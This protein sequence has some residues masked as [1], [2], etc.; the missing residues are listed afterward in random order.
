MSLAKHPGEG[1]RQRAGLD[2]ARGFLHVVLHPD[3]LDLAIPPVRLRPPRMAEAMG[4]SSLDLR[5]LRS[6]GVSLYLVLP[7][8]HLDTYVRWLRLVVA[9]ALHELARSPGKPTVN[10]RPHRVLFL[11]DEFAHL[12]RMNPVLRAFGLMAGFGVQVWA[13]L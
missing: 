5:R 4:S 2:G 13:F 9:C 3:E 7:A 10:G 8:H 12:G 6:E 11:L 1:V